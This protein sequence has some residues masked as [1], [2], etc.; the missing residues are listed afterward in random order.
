M[1]TSDPPGNEQ[2]AVDYLKQV[3]EK[4]GIPVQLFALESRRPNLVARI[5]GNG[6]KRPIL[7]MGH[8]DTV[9]VDPSK[10]THGPFSADRDGGYIYGRGTLDNKSTVVTALMIMLELK[11]QNVP[12]DRDVIFLAEAGEEGNTR[13]GIDFMVQQHFADIDAEYCFA[14]TGIANRENG[15]VTYVTVQ[16]TEKQ[17]RAI[18]LVARGT[19]G[20]AS[21]PLL[22]NPVVPLGAA[23]EKIGNWQPPISL[24]ETTGTYF[25]RLAQIAPPAAAQRYRDLLDP[26]KATAVDRYFREN[27]VQ[28]SA[29]L[30]MTLSPT[31]VSAGY[32]LNVI[33]S[34]AKATVDLRILPDD[35]PVAVLEMVRKVVN[36]PA[37]TVQYAPRD[38]RPIGVSR[39]DTEA[40]KTI[41]ANVTK[42]YAAPTLPTMGTGGTDMAYVRAKGLQCYGL[43]P[44]QDVED[45]PRGFGSHSDQERIV[46]SELHR[47]VRFHWDVVSDLARKR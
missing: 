40:Y 41:E 7:I 10:W 23:I 11:R 47:F 43:G 12:L 29:M 3:L 8:T 45:P 9:N 24:N 21:K 13:V 33:P 36:D 14:E 18:E 42:H 25:R 46:E 15:K 22:S 1:D 39:L 19:S 17:P 27:E 28:H 32:R 20:H 38:L 5:K 16:T 44:G 34:D 4:E 31:M 30:H 35:D 37:V 26:A 2:P 6:S